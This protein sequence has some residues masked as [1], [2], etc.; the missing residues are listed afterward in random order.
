MWL[1]KY[2]TW[3]IKPGRTWRDTWACCGR[4][5]Q[6]PVHQSEAIMWS[7]DTLCFLS[8]SHIVYFIFLHQTSN[9]S[10]VYIN[11][12]NKH[13]NQYCCFQN[14][15]LRLTRF[16]TSKARD[17]NSRLLE[18]C[19][20]SEK[21][22][23]CVITIRPLST[24]GSA[25]PGYIHHNILINTITQAAGHLIRA[26]YVVTSRLQA[27]PWNCDESNTTEQKKRW[28]N[29]EEKLQRRQPAGHADSY[30]T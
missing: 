12:D 7:G 23:P 4:T 27:D 2:L 5:P 30:N 1:I 10:N 26:D 25:V 19:S 11:V 28:H 8:C 18:L 29:T 16:W 20:S 22:A 21:I 6:I 14:K 17:L 15:S 13:F 9:V 24:T 3:K